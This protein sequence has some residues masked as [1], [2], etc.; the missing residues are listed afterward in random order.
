MKQFYIIDAIGFLFR[1]FFAIRGM[2]GPDGTPTNALFGFIRSIEKL[3]QD[4]PVEHCIAVFD[5]PNNK[6]SRTK[7]YPAYKG[8]RSQMP[9]DLF[10]QLDLAHQFCDLYGIPQLSIPNVEAD[11]VIGTL[12]KKARQQGFQ[13][14]IV[15]QDKDLCQLVDEHTYLIQTHKDNLIVDSAKVKEIYGVYPHQITD[16][17]AIIGDSSDNIPGIEGMGPK[18]ATKLLEEFGTLENLYKNLDQ[19]DNEK[20]RQKI[21]D[22]K[23]LAF[24]S[25]ELATLQFDVEVPQSWEFYQKKT[26][27][28]SHLYTF[29]EK[30]GFKTLIKELP[31]DSHSSTIKKPSHEFLTQIVDDEKKLQDALKTL[32]TFQEICVDCETTSLNKLEAQI[33]GIGLGATE[34]TVYYIPFNGALSQ[35]TLFFHLEPFFQNPSLCFFGH[36]LKYDLHCLKNAGFFPKKISFDTMIAS[37]VLHPENNRHNL[38]DLSEEILHLK[39]IPIE[40]LIGEGKKQISMADVP[41]DAIARYCTEDVYATICLKNHFAPLIEKKGLTDVFYSIDLP[42][43]PILYEME[44]HGIFVDQSRLKELSHYLAKE[45]HSLEKKIYELAGKEF[46][47]KSPKQL[48]EILF[49]DLSI[50][51]KTKKT[52]T[53]FSTSADVL[54]E[55]KDKHPIVPLVLQYRTLEKLRSTYVDA[56]PE[57]VS[58]KTSRIHCTFN[59]S[60]TATGRLSC[61]DPNLQNIPVRT[62]IGTEIRS[63][64]C[65]QKKES[66]FLGAD[67]SQIELRI[68][69]HLSEDETLINAFKKD[70]D[71]HRLTASL[72]F[73]VPKEHVTDEMRYKAKAVNFGIIYGQQ[74]FG[75][76]KEIGISMKEAAEFIRR[77][78]ERYPSV[79][80]FLEQE[81]EKARKTGVSR[82]MMGRLR[83]I[84]DIDSKNPM[85][86]AQAERYAIN[87]PIQ[88]SQSDLIKL[89][90]I[91]IDHLFKKNHLKSF[92]ILQIHDELIFEVEQTELEQVK[93]IVQETMETIFPLKVPLK[94]NISVGKNWGEC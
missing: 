93:Q 60:V 30:Y 69:A 80:K 48:S 62:D 28:Y 36:N 5:G 13:I 49:V 16:Y 29:Y 81:K 44:R 39:K 45:I 46:N 83:V 91:K 92:L 2:K 6:A 31:E 66:L 35:D 88:G 11:D 8:H 86:R 50:S 33:V 42:L 43:I 22:A 21:F 37:Y 85:L 84:D 1:S 71:I 17:L 55:I 67:Y 24:L 61:Q 64:F 82:S 89:A 59:Q 94:V 73:D 3:F 63:A 40:S 7:I 56:L 12:T 10:A 90:M 18:N 78:F 19:I 65:P 74:A 57:Q 70:E 34:K 9:D 77:Y 23:D 54:E 47:I 87:T 52:T 26:P 27:D 58:S 32:S 79:A 75:L 41:I 51:T 20:K 4:F 25:K 14:C 38:D 72:I 76:S 68:L 53:G 15:S